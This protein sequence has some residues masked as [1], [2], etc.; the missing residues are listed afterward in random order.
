MYNGLEGAA[1]RVIHMRN[2]KALWLQLWLPGGGRRVLVA[3][4]CSKL[5]H[6][7]GQ[8]EALALKA[9]GCSPCWKV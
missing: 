6:S 2:D 9:A 4:T 8:P 7:E 1:R 3:S 5:W